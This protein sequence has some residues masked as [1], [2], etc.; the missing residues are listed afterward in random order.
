MLLGNTGN[1]KRNFNA[2]SKFFMSMLTEDEWS[3]WE[4]RIAFMKLSIGHGWLSAGCAAMK[5]H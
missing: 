1:V 3:C 4:I 5:N 2:A